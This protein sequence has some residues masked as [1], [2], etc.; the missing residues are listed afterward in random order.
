MPRRSHVPAKDLELTLWTRTRIRA[1]FCTIEALAHVEEY[2][3]LWVP[4]LEIDGPYVEELT[5]KIESTIYVTPRS[6]KE[7]RKGG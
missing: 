5:T 3:G 4:L 6:M 2:P 7:E 1:R